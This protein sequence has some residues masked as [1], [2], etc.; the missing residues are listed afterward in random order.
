MRT[1]PEELIRES[2]E[3]ADAGWEILETRDAGMP[4]KQARQAAQ[5]KR[6]GKYAP[7]IDLI[8]KLR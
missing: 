4:G 1:S 8:T 3:K 5:F 2:L 7:E 6:A